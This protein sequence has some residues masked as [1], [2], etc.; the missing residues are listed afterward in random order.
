MIRQSQQ[1]GQ[2][3]LLKLSP[4]QIQLLN[5]LQLNTLELE[6][7][8]KDELEENPALEA[9]SSTSEA[10]LTLPETES[11]SGDA[12]E[13]ESEGD[14]EAED[15]DRFEL[16]EQYHQDDDLPE[17][18][19]AVD[20]RTTDDLP[21]SP[22]LVQGSDFRE[23]L[24]DQL[25]MMPL[26]DRERL[27]AGYLVD[28]LDDDGYL[29]LELDDIADNLSFA[30]GIF[31]VT[32]ELES[33]LEIVQGLEPVGVGARDLREC[34]LLQLEAKQHNVACIDLSYT[35]VKKHLNDLAN[36]NYDKLINLLGVSAQ[37][38][39]CATALIARLNPRPV[40]SN[41]AEL[42]KNQN[43]IPEFVVEKTDDGQFQVFLANGN[44][45]S[46]RI[47]GDMVQMLESM[48]RDKSGKRDKAAV[49][50]LRSKVDSAIWF[51]EMVRQ[52]EQSML[53]SMQAIV[54]LQRDYFRSGDEKD[55]HPMILKDV[56][57]QTGLDISTI[58]R[59]TS[60]KY[61]LAPFGIVHL[62]ELF[63]GGLAKTDGEMVT[64]KEISD[65]ISELIGL[66]NK[67]NPITDQEMADKLLEKGYHVAR[68]TVAKYRDAMNIPVAKMRKAL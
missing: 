67:Q 22:T 28:S 29:R 33:A 47:S 20:Q 14:A 13:T 49:Q 58:S 32:S 12:P 41:T 1:Q 27:L 46:L 18:K 4:Q 10:D 24:K 50:Y 42:V 35:I 7:K 63:N 56:A 9:D 8:I 66:E 16:L 51:V 36:R 34:L 11:T 45:A 65:I 44:S 25:V 19:T 61:A 60:M 21:F 26:D 62:K 40:G 6:Q 15:Y 30:H 2:K 43:I 68:R 57:E 23:Q 59:V 38:M 48:Q 52:R 5:F 54:T 55:L 3:Q 31:V 37:D 64:N 53:K 39:K 17:Y